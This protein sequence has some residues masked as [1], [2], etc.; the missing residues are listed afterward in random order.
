MDPRY[1]IRLTGKIWPP[2]HDA[3]I[4]VGDLFSLNAVFKPIPRET[5]LLR[6]N[7]LGSPTQIL[8]PD[9]VRMLVTRKRKSRNDYVVLPEW[10]LLK[11]LFDTNIVTPVPKTAEAEKRMREA[12]RIITG[13]APR[14]L[15]EKS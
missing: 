8:S 1:T 7:W 3:Y 2:M 13:F 12:L 9:T 4:V 10:V 6:N 15:P 14:T 5:Y 11:D